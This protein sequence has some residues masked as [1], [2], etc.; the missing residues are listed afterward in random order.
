ML[1]MILYTLSVTEYLPII[2]DATYLSSEINFEHDHFQ[3]KVSL[4]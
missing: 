1:H 2:P 3:T 4:I